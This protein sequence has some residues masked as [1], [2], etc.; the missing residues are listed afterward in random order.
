MNAR[1]SI[2]LGL[3]ALVALLMTA[4]AALWLVVPARAAA[5]G[6]SWRPPVGGAAGP[7][8]PPE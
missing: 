3:V 4:N 1:R 2:M 8:T 6:P 7:D 5:A